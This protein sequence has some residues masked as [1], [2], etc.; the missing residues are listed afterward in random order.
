M[1]IRPLL[2]GTALT[3]VLSLAIGLGLCY[4]LYRIAQDLPS[5]PTDPAELG[6]RPGTE[7]YA[8][9]GQR[10]YTFNQSRQWVSLEHI[11]PHVLHA[12]IATEDAD[13]YTHRGIDLKA[14]AGAARDNLLKG[15]RTRGGSTLTQQLV[16]RL[17]F[18]PQ[19]NLKRKLSEALLS[20]QLEAHFA[21]AYPDTNAQ[22]QPVYKDHLLELYLNEVF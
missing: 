22:G 21:T 12:L 19:K 17:F 20:L 14:I 5:L 4:A 2:I 6:I 1:N 8:A 7:I 13:F 18:S 11:S 16:K 15:Y 10:I 3:V 9:S